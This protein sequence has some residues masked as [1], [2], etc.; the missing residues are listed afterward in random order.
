MGIYEKLREILNYYLLNKISC[1]KTTQLLKTPS[2][3]FLTPVQGPRTPFHRWYGPVLVVIGPLLEPP[4]GQT[5]TF[6]TGSTVFGTPRIQGGLSGY[7]FYRVECA[8]L[9]RWTIC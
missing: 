7:T 9:P 5:T 6:S 1:I 8:P 2:L 3:L 4:T